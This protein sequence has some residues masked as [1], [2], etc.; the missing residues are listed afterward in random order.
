MLMHTRI[1]AI[2]IC[3]VFYAMVKMQQSWKLII[4]H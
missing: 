2:I 4:K 1:L 3:T